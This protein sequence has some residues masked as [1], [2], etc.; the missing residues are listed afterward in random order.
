[1]C[2]VSGISGVAAWVQK[3]CLTAICVSTAEDRAAGAARRT[4]EQVEGWFRITDSRLARAGL[5]QIAS[6]STLPKA[7]TAAPAMTA[8]P[9]RGDL[10]ARVTTYAT[11]AAAVP[12]RLRSANCYYQPP[13]LP[14]AP[15][16]LAVRIIVA[17]PEQGWSMLRNRVIMFDDTGAITPA[18]EVIC[19][20]PTG[21][22]TLY[23]VGW[24][25]RR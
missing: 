11:P 3:T 19:S 17:S 16:R 14:M 24:A 20:P 8:E 9:D 7:R 15:D 4:P 12:A 2:W 23:R 18:G 13:C 10:L 1:M 5:D 25:G 6:A 22:L 21:S